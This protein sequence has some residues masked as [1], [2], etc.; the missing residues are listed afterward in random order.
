MIWKVLTLHAQVIYGV[1]IEQK[2]IHKG[3]LILALV[4]KLNIIINPSS[5]SID[6]IFNIEK[7]LLN[8]KFQTSRPKPVD[9]K[10][11]LIQ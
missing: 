10:S 11:T 4:S 9:I 6:S 5:A 8:I 7:F 1:S 3:Y 2:E